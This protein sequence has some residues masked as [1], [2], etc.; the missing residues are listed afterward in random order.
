MSD[1]VSYQ[2]LE[3]VKPIDTAELLLRSI[4]AQLIHF[5]K[6]ELNTQHVHKFN[7]K[8][9]VSLHIQNFTGETSFL[10]NKYCWP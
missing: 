10:N 2:P 6:P 5:F 4:E 7:A 8:W 3:W 1:D 9:P